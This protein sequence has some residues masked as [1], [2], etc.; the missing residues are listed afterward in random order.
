MFSVRC[1]RS[2][3]RS[4]RWVLWS[5]VVTFVTVLSGCSASPLLPAEPEPSVVQTVANPW[6]SVQLQRTIAAFKAPVKAIALSPDGQ[7]L[8]GGS[9][10][11]NTKLWAVETGEAV[12]SLPDRPS[13]QS[14]AVSPANPAG[15]PVLMASGD[16]Q[17]GIELHNLSTGEQHHSMQVPDTVV[18]SVAF[19]PTGQMLASGHWD[20]TLNLWDVTTG[21]RLRTL[22]DHSYGVTVV[23]FTAASGQDTESVLVS[24]DYDGSINLWEP[25]SG[26]L[27]RTFSADRYPIFAL[28][29]APDGNLLVEGSGNG[30]I[31]SWTLPSAQY[32]QGFTGHLDAVT[33]LAISPDG[34]TLASGSR[35]RTIKLW[36]LATGNLLQT[37]NEAEMD[38]ILSLTFSPNGEL[39]ISGDQAGMIQIWQ[40]Q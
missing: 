3:C 31:K 9:L 19:S 1:S 34:K 5:G 33:A 30:T 8:I 2:L 22:S 14:I 25:T 15:Q 35:D 13:I 24:A 37:L 11:G 16:Y 26:E 29:I 27:L 10:N 12:R 4:H 40:R 18:Q 7:T 28:S 32:V 38:S 39:L 36:D 17:G 23:A 20:G 21:D 6:R